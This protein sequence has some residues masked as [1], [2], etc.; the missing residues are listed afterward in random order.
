MILI[1]QVAALCCA[2]WVAYQALSKESSDSNPYVI[3]VCC[4]FVAASLAGSI[5]LPSEGDFVTFMRMLD[6]LSSYAALPMIATALLVAPF[7]HNWS[8]AGWGRLLLGFFAAFEL[9]RRSELGEHY[10]FYLLTLSA[11]LILGRLLKGSAKERV[12]SLLCAATLFSHALYAPFGLLSNE[13]G[14]AIIS[15]LMLIPFFLCV[16]VILN[17]AQ[18][19]QGM[20]EPLDS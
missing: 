16:A 1:V 14:A 20:K 10:G 11:G 12:A 15:S 5:L 9:M 6:S 18:A 7:G 4:L 2:L 13:A 3:A 17:K 19:T 8:R